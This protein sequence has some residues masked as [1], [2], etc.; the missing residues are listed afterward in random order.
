M[1]TFCKTSQHNTHNTNPRALAANSSNLL[2]Q[3]ILQLRNV[4]FLV[5]QIHS[6]FFIL[7]QLRQTLFTIR[8]TLNTVT[9]VHG[10]RASSQIFKWNCLKH[11]DQFFQVG[12]MWSYAMW[13]VNQ[14]NLFKEQ[15][16]GKWWWTFV[17]SKIEKIHASCVAPHSKFFSASWC[18]V[19]IGSSN[20]KF[21]S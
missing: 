4:L 2:R 9:K 14:F 11:A 7:F 21:Q 1:A 10:C 20:L 8:Q 3:H 17:A 6:Y 13:S 16:N 5:F 19:S 12:L 15:Y 18:A